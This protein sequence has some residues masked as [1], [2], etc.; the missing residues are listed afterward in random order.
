M[1]R[2]S[3]SPLLATFLQENTTNINEQRPRTMT[4]TKEDPEITVNATP[5]PLAT[6][7]GVAAGVEK[8]AGGASNEPPIPAGH[9]RF[10]CSKCRSVRSLPCLVIR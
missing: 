7:V 4:V 2:A 9:S 5:E 10:Y 6:A 8:P 3:C 1:K